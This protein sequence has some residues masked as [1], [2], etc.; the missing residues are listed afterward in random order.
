MNFDMFIKKIC[1]R[2][3]VFVIRYLQGGSRSL[4]S[5]PHLHNSR[6]PEAMPEQN[7]SQSVAPSESSVLFMK[8]RYGE[9]LMAGSEIINE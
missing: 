7:V 3:R 4:N 9:F 8:R 1:S 5:L 6:S 2:F